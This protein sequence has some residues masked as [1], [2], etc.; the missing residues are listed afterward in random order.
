MGQLINQLNFMIKNMHQLFYQITKEGARDAGESLEN[1]SM[2]IDALVEGVYR[3]QMDRKN[4]HGRFIKFG[5]ALFFLI[6]ALQY[7]LQVETYLELLEMWYVQI[8][9]HLI[10]I[11]NA[12]FLLKGEKYYNADV[13]VEE[14][15][16]L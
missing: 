6:L 10:I 5:L 1:M 3:D 2:D 12:S 16:L 14:Y 13:G 9:L 7:M 8:L 4:F 15:D 11:L